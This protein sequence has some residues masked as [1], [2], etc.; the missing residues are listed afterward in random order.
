MRNSRTFL[1]YKSEVDVKWACSTRSHLGIEAELRD[2]AGYNAAI[3]Q[4][5]TLISNLSA[6]VTRGRY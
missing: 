2:V 6:T 4:L 5:S 1:G 3:S